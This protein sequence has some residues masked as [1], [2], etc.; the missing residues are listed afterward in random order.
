MRSNFSRSAIWFALLILSQCVPWSHGPRA[1]G[2]SLD[3]IDPSTQPKET[4]SLASLGQAEFPALEGPIDPSTY[5]LGPG[6]ELELAIY[7][8][9][10]ARVPVLVDAVGAIYVPNVGHLQVGGLT[11]VEA[12][13]RLASQFQKEYRGVHGDLSLVRPRRI[14]VHVTGEVARPGIVEIQAPAR[15]SDAV[16]LGGGFGPNASE[17]NIE[18]LRRG[19]GRSLADLG[20]YRRLGSIADNPALDNGD[21]VL[22]PSR[23]QSME[24]QGEVPHPGTLEFRSGDRLSGIIALGGGLQASADSDS[25]EVWR[26]DGGAGARALILPMREALR[27][28]GVDS[29]IPARPGD[30]F[31][32]RNSP[33]WH[34][35]ASVQVFGDVEKPGTY[36]IQP[37]GE[38]A[39]ELI[40][41]F[42]GFSPFADI[43]SAT[44]Y[45]PSLQPTRDTA[46]INALRN[47]LKELS[48]E[49]A[50]FL[51]IHALAQGNLSSKLRELVGVHQASSD[52][53]LLDGDIILVPGRTRSVAVYG[54]V[55]RPGVVAFQEGALFRDYIEM[56]GGFGDRADQGKARVTQ[57]TTGQPVS[58]SDVA[59]IEEG[60]II[61]VP[62]QEPRNFLRTVSGVMGFLAQLA[63]V[64]LVI[65]QATIK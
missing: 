4:R 43:R 27:M 13:E 15:V 40:R 55:R 47:G 33:D 6:D 31:F 32:V 44:V 17:R 34:R 35:R 50:E 21:V 36:A 41:R 18:V 46:Y 10:T 63:T 62:E 38:L 7:G 12:R 3:P 59:M 29:D 60:D 19:G 56:V 48:H 45:R 64:Y 23:L 20:K 14:K 25:V 53:R 58:A 54:A 1:Q 51:K 24:I 42:G 8:R 30:R 61:W 22:V 26:F 37:E 16:R 28:P 11:L 52:F 49:D 57:V 65:H 9:A 5:I 2:N 39:S